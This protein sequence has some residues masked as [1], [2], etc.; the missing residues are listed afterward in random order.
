VDEK[1]LKEEK[2]KTLRR[3]SKKMTYIQAV[4]C[5]DSDDDISF[6]PFDTSSEEFSL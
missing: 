6:A 3:I 2:V 5:D 4:P 1:K